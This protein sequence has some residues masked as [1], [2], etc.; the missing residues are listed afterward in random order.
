MRSGQSIFYAYWERQNDLYAS[1]WIVPL[2]GS[3]I[4]YIED[5][6]KFNFNAVPWYCL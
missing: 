4:I 1:N 2:H 3:N 6:L 5:T